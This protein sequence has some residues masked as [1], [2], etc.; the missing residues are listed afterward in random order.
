MTFCLFIENY[1]NHSIKIA[2]SFV[3]LKTQFK[4]S[5]YRIIFFN[6]SKTLVTY[7][8]QISLNNNS[9]FWRIGIFWFGRKFKIE[10]DFEL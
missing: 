5:K 9:G 6:F 10:N 1:M 2:T 4:I 8:G 3:R 7:L